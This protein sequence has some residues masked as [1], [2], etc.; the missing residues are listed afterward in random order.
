MPKND[1]TQSFQLQ[2]RGNRTNPGR[3]GRTYW[4]LKLLLQKLQRTLD[5]DL[6]PPGKNVLDFGCADKP[7]LSLFV[8][9]FP[10][11]VGADLPGNPQAEVNIGPA[12]DL[13]CAERSFDCV[14]SS[15]VLE[16]VVDPHQYLKEA[17]R[18]LRDGGSLVL[19]TH[20]VWPYHPDPTDY[21]RWTIDGLQEEIRRAGF[22]IMMVQSVFGIESCALQLWQD[23]TFERLPRVIQPAYTWFFQLLIGFIERRQPDKLSNDAS[24]YVVLAR[25]KGDHV[26]R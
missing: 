26:T 24:I 6:L 10:K 19:S 23:A 21:W 17:F 15:Q 2:E 9:K 16:H 8:E 1:S 14:L 18:V 12:G 22:E 3:S 5:S 4:S 20:G 25:K 11:Y 13:P 7:Y